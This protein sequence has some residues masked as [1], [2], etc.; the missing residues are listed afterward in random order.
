[1]I[2]IGEYTQGNVLFFMLGLISTFG[3]VEA[4]NLLLKIK[5]YE[6]V[7]KFAWLPFVGV[8]VA[9]GLSELG[10]PIQDSEALIPLA[11]G[12]SLGFLESYRRHVN[13]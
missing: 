5:N 6:E 12:M 10:M 13:E 2:E 4:L 11:V 9:L 1:M 3:P 7:G 8:M